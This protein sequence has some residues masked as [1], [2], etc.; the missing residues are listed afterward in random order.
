MPATNRHLRPN[1]AP[2]SGNIEETSQYRYLLNGLLVLLLSA[3]SLNACHAVR[4]PV[5]AASNE[6]APM[7]AVTAVEQTVTVRGQAFS[8]QDS[9]TVIPGMEMIFWNGLADS[10]KQNLRTLT[11]PDGAYRVRLSAG[12]TYQ[13]ALNKDGRNVGM[14]RYA[15]PGMPADSSGPIHNFYANYADTVAIGGDPLSPMLF[16]D[17]NQAAL[18]P[19]SKTRLD[20]LIPVLK[21]NPGIRVSIEGHAEPG[22][23]PHSQPQ[24][25]QYLMQLGQRRA[26]TVAEY[27]KKR[28]VA[29][30]R[31]FTKSYGGRQLVVPNDNPE[32]RQ[33]NRRV[34]F[35]V[36][37]VEN[38][39]VK[40]K[41]DEHRPTNSMKPKPRLSGPTH[42]STTRNGKKA[43]AKQ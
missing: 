18:R 10:T 30:N 37:S 25:D 14:Q 22:E 7:V 5:S 11:G 31:V 40:R 16:F 38:I 12:Q 28:G 41:V 27:F 6:P 21:Y 19:E 35:R 3:I 13:V 26:Q 1:A 20:N 23:V 39:A 15:V 36:V 43:P 42:S 34:E 24:P 17:T 2:S 4:G 8:T 9:T 33:L 32:N 29:A